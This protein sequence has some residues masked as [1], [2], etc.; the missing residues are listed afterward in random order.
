VETRVTRVPRDPSF[1]YRGTE[2]TMSAT[3]SICDCVVICVFVVSGVSCL[4]G[5]WPWQK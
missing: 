2:E 4:L 5:R 1:N 3:Q